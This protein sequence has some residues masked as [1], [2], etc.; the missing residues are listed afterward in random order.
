M[1]KHHAPATPPDLTLFEH[2]ADEPDD[3]RHRMTMN[4]LALAATIG[5]VMAGVWIA[6]VMAHMRTDQDCVLTGRTA[7]A[8]I[9]APPR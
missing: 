6:D 9:E 8:V 1:P 2:R 4:A 7:C 5:L 3:Y